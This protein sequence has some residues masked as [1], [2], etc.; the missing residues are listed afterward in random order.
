MF[1]CF[2]ANFL[3]AAAGHVPHGDLDDAIAARRPRL[4]GQ[5]LLEGHDAESVALG[6]V[7]V[8]VVAARRHLR[9]EPV[10]LGSA[11]ALPDRRAQRSDYEVKTGS[12]GEFDNFIHQHVSYYDAVYKC[13][14]KLLGTS[15][16][17]IPTTT[18]I[19]FRN[20][21]LCAAALP[22]HADAPPGDGVAL[23]AVLVEAGQE[24]VDQIPL[25]LLG[26]MEG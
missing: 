17:K 24:A 10:E 5:E 13:T 16:L 12:G 21:P 14:N 2:L 1:S 26:R 11:V 6:V 25:L 4:P 18:R 23:E 20:N 19:S 3:E 9:V 22:E 8:V 15:I 7:L